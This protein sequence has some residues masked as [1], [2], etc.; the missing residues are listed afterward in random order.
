M[1]SDLYIMRVF[2][3]LVFFNMEITESHMKWKMFYI[4][5]NKP[6]ITLTNKRTDITLDKELISRI[7]I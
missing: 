3:F 1:A 5:A 7:C 4:T 6:N 2:F